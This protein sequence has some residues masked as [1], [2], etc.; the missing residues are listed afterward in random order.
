MNNI[1]PLITAIN[2][3]IVAP[4]IYE[5]I[6]RK[7]T[8]NWVE[9]STK[10]TEELDIFLSDYTQFIWQKRDSYYRIDAYFNEDIIYI[11]DINASFV[12]GWW[13]ALNFSR[14]IWQEIDNILLEKFPQKMYLQE[15][16]YRPEFQLCIDEMNMLWIDTQEIWELIDRYKTYVYGTLPK[17]ENAFPFDGLRIDNKM[18]LA[19]F[20]KQWKGTNIQIPNI[21]TP[22]DIG[23]PDTPKD[24]VYKVSSKSDISRDGWNVKIWKPK[25]GKWASRKWE[26]YKMIAQER[27]ETMKNR[28]G[29]NM[30]LIIMCANDVAVT[31][32]VQ[33]ST[34]E[35]INDNSNQS[36]IILNK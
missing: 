28:D 14:S 32:Y 5:W 19:L 31:G 17:T 9:L 8:N 6:Q 34:W 15:Q 1:T 22:T 33:S 11:I 35:Q 2:P 24:M 4:S 26:Q 36:P 29:E 25:N 20:A 12:D 30:Q 13:N 23:W 27:V 10:I 21:I 7:W 3:D 16:Q 18:N